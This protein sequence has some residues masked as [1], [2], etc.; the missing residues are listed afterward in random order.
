MLEVRP[1]CTS[2]LFIPSPALVHVSE[3]SELSLT[4]AE[5]AG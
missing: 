1:C 3:G 5:A 4:A 2:L